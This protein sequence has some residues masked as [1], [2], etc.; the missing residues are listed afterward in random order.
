[1]K[2]VSQLPLSVLPVLLVGVG[3]LAAF[4]THAWDSRTRPFDVHSLTNEET[5]E[6]VKWLDRYYASDEGLQRPGGMVLDGHVDHEAIA[7]WLL[8][9][10]LQARAG[11]AA[12]E[13]ARE[14]VAAAIRDSPE[15]RQKHGR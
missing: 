11:G 7:D 8:L 14:A 2:R 6:T 5:I 3:L 1:M 13:K 4:A 15:W 10:Y 9:N 12:P